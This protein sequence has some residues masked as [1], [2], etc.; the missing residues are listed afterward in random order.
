MNYR[1]QKFTTI[2]PEFVSQFL[3]QTPNYECLSYQDLYDRFVGTHYGWSNYFAKHIESFGNIAEDLFASFEPLQKM[4]A[5]ENNVKYS[6]E[7]WL[8]EIVCAQIRKFQPDILF[9]QDLYLF[10]QSFRD[11][12][13]EICKKSV[14]LVGWRAAPTSDF[15]SFKDLDLI[16]SCIPLFVKK[17]RACGCN[18]AY[19]PMGFEHTVL[20]SIKLTQNR[21]FDFTFAGS[22]GDKH[23]AHSQRYALIEK[24]MDNTPLQVWSNDGAKLKEAISSQF[25]NR[26]HGPVFGL[27]FYELLAQSKIIFNSHIDC[28]ENYAANMR[29]YEATGMGVCLLTDWKDNLSKIF[30][31]E[32]EVITYRS[33]EE[34]IEK[35]HYLLEHDTERQAIAV[36][37]QQRTLKD[38]ALVDRVA[39][40]NNLIMKM[41][42][43]FS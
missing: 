7:N 27:P 20:D 35:V 25:K 42:A 38:H 17:M 37:G 4:W 18:A 10:D 36:A 8:K 14:I 12:V 43:K 28:V 11:Q 2:Y 31:P 24:M 29:L 1:F 15:S 34:A 41:L 6:D 9:L 40:V 3:E 16:L 26:F 32:E 33:G 22:L 5:Y 19:I 23:G 30:E 21:T 13:R 39:T